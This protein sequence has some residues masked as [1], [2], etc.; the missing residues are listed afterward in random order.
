MA[1]TRAGGISAWGLGAQA[2]HG[3]LPRDVRHRSRSLKRWSTVTRDVGMFSTPA[4]PSSGASGDVVVTVSIPFAFSV[5][6]NDGL[7]LD[8][9]SPD[10]SYTYGTCLT[11]R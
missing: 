9:P 5:V 6:S 1:A 2:G 8:T 10:F 4:A 7:P 11:S 3:T